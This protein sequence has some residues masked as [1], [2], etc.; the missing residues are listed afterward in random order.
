MTPSGPV[1]A[2]VLAHGELVRVQPSNLV[3]VDLM[4]LDEWTVSPAVAPRAFFFPRGKGLSLNRQH[5]FTVLFTARGLSVASSSCGMVNPG[6]QQTLPEI[7]VQSLNQSQFKE[8]VSVTHQLLGWDPRAVSHAA[9]GIMGII[10]NN[11]QGLFCQWPME[12][13]FNKG[14]D[15][16]MQRF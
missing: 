8:S 4:D 6:S 14:P 3:T 7:P 10:G 9:N 1:T 11:S 15:M 16:K 2:Q 5:P 13:Q 12:L